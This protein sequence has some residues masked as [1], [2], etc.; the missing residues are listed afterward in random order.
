MENKTILLVE[1]NPD[2]EMLTLRA[3]KR[4]RIE[5]QIVVV[6]DGVEALEYLFCTGAYSKRDPNDMPALILLDLRLPKVDGVEVLRRI[7][8]DE[9]TTLLQVIILTSSN[10]DRD[11]VAS[12]TYGA[13]AYMQKPVDFVQFTEAVREL[14][15]YLFVVNEASRP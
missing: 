13:N 15:L 2:D 10:A 8:K 11:M 12:L 14:G 4:N 3:L 6:R 5:N 1:D 7:R 9:R